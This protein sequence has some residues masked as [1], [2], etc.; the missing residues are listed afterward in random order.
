MGIS[1]LANGIGLVY[2]TAP[3]GIT[4]EL[5]V[6][7]TPEDVTFLK[8]DAASR[9][10]VSGEILATGTVLIAALP[11]SGGNI[12]D[13]SV[14]GI[15][16]MAA[17]INI[18]I[19]E[20]TT[21]ILVADAINLSPPTSGPRYTAQAV[22]NLITLTGPTGSGD[23]NNGDLITTTA[24][25]GITLTT[26]PIDGGADGS[27]TFDALSGSRYFLNADPGA[28]EGD[29]TGSEEITDFLIIRGLQ[30][31]PIIEALVIAAGTISLLRRSQITAIEIKNESD[32]ANDDLDFIDPSGFQ[33]GD[34]IKITGDDATQIATLRDKSVSGGNIKLANQQ[35][36]PTGEKESNIQL[37][38]TLDTGGLTIWAEYSR[39]PG[40]I[41]TGDSFWEAG[42]P[43]DFGHRQ[44]ELTAGGGTITVKIDKP[45]DKTH[46]ELITTGLVA[47][48]ANWSIQFTGGPPKDGQRVEVEYNGTVTLGT[49][50]INI[51]GIALSI[52]EAAVGGIRITAIW[53][54]ANSVW[55]FSKFYDHLK[56][57]LIQTV[58]LDDDAV[59]EIKIVDEAVTVNKIKDDSVSTS[60]L[61]DS[62]VT[63]IKLNNAAVIID[64]LEN[65][66]KDS[67]I[68]LAVSFED[69]ELGE[70]RFYPGFK[71]ILTR[72]ISRVSA[73]LAPT[74]AGTIQ[75]ANGNGNMT[76]GLITHNSNSSFGDQQEVSPTTNQDV[77]PGGA[78]DHFKFTTV[79]GNTGGKSNLVL[80]LTRVN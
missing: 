78:N 21:A 69:E 31:N 26:T 76:N 20:S 44:E 64:K 28:L 45:L 12:S 30:S 17:A 51:F 39:S 58:N 63:S 61:Q 75:T 66:L 7:N 52:K 29:L 79:K 47:L 48:T 14:N 56:A 73:D 60:K 50:S 6:S 68:G 3:D 36:F 59:T 15:N 33:I 11:P 24:S 70:Y 77:D 8:R 18:V 71:C 10:P 80:F 22:G 74:N 13:V 46:L 25:D 2:K 62:S 16:Q 41:L 9:G 42:L 35:S 54:D 4:V 19:N 43:V 53:D 55:E 67:T 49:F 72:I 37:F 23:N 32:A 65:S 1:K 5:T 57:G 27:K 34:K 38:L 40:Q